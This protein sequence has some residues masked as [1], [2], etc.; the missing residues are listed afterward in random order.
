M[1][2]CRSIKPCRP[3]SSNFFSCAFQVS[4]LTWIIPRH[5]TSVSSCNVCSD[6]V[7]FFNVLNSFFLVNI[8]VTMFSG[9]IDSKGL[10][11]LSCTVCRVSCRNLET[12][13]KLTQLL[14]WIQQKLKYTHTH[15]HTHI[16]NLYPIWTCE[17]VFN[18]VI[19]YL[20]E[21]KTT[22]I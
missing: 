5:L 12:V 14:S 6:R 10:S 1:C 20:P 22:L 21:C 3:Y 2:P 4:P 17:S 8:T 9:L 16:T 19:L 18:S 13:L 7:N 15:T 11:H